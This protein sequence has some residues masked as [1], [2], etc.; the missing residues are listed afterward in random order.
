MILMLFFENKLS[1]DE[2]RKAGEYFAVGHQ[3]AMARTFARRFLFILCNIF[4]HTKMMNFIKKIN[5]EDTIMKIKLQSGFTPHF[6]R[7]MV[8]LILCI[9]PEFWF[10]LKKVL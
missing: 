7:E 5:I 3:A 1:S 2:L 4:D 8:S 6:F 9:I 10:C